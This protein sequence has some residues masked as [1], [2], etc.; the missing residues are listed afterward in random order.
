MKL[1][2][3]ILNSMILI[4]CGEGIL[5]NEEAK[6]KVE[7]IPI[8]APSFAFT[9]V[10]DGDSGSRAAFDDYGW[11]TDGDAIVAANGDV[12]VATFT[13]ADNTLPTCTKLSFAVQSF[14]GSGAQDCDGSNTP[15]FNSCTCSFNSMS[16]TDG[17][18][19]LVLNNVC[20]SD[21]AS[22]GGDIGDS[23]DIGL[24]FNAPSN[25]PSSATVTKTYKW[26]IQNSD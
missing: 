5:E 10:T 25:A 14:V 15:T 24:R 11:P 12:P 21:N 2:F 6:E 3:I 23:I 1:L 4:S 16:T 26:Y 19:R 7:E 8:T 22:V 20:G 17:T 9:P 18:C 13:N